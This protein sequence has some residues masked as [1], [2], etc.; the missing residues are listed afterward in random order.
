MTIKHLL[1]ATRGA[2]SPNLNQQVVIT[3]A[4]HVCKHYS[5]G[6]PLGVNGMQRTH[7][8]HACSNLKYLLSLVLTFYHVK[9][10]QRT[11]VGAR[12]F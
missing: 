10:T 1:Q 2:H 5:F 7:S 6:V 11:R 4:S 9:V 3:H 8:D 12:A